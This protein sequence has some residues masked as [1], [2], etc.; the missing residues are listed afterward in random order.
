[1]ETE[2]KQYDFC[3]KCGALMEGGYCQSCGY[4]THENRVDTVLGKQKTPGGKGRGKGRI[5]CLA[6]LL[7]V[8]AA[9]LGV[10]GIRTLLGTVG[11]YVQ[12]AEKAG[13]PGKQEPYRGE[14][15]EEELETDELWD[16][17]LIRSQR[18]PAFELLYG[19][20]SVA[21]GRPALPAVTS[22]TYE[23]KPEDDFYRCLTDAIEYDLSYSV[24]WESMPVPDAEGGEVECTV[25]QV[26]MED[27]EKEERINAGILE[28]LSGRDER[29]LRGMEV[30][31]TYMSEE[32]LS[33]AGKEL[34]YYSGQDFHPFSLSAVS[35]DMSTG[36]TLAPEDMIEMTPGWASRFWGLCAY[37]HPDDQVV[38][39]FSY[40][41]PEE[42]EE[43]GSVLLANL[44]AL[45]EKIMDPETG[46]LFYT[47]VGLEAGFNH[48]DGFITVTFDREQ[49]LPFYRYWLEEPDYEPMA[50]DPYYRQLV[51]AI[52]DDLSYQV[53]FES[54][55]LEDETGRYHYTYPQLS[56]AGIPNLEEINARI[57]EVC[58]VHA[59][60]AAAGASGGMEILSYV[61][62]MDE[63]VISI[64]AEHLPY[65]LNSEGLWQSS[66][67]IDSITFDL[68]NGREI[69][70]NEIVEMDLELAKQFQRLAGE[71]E[72][73]NGDVSLLQVM[74]PEDLLK[75]D[76][77]DENHNFVFYTPAGIE[78]GYNEIQ[79]SYSVTIKEE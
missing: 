51:N 27:K 68:V 41:E 77:V 13:K 62:Y 12:M 49:S 74:N 37:E 56:G 76:L 55:S 75:N 53:E 44:N 1:M 31:V 19:N 54:F 33:I 78:V 22:L 67:S 30:Y 4:R 71:Q 65:T 36:G 52:Q 58:C 28:L 21:G 34:A 14:D 59:E 32:I 46:I 3:P 17:S 24:Q 40:A 50:S 8:A 16:G 60:E 39:T 9:A 23:P 64:V 43:A 2:K 29:E 5:V 10:H 7:S 66:S 61:T 20:Y 73:K 57:Q 47:P 70:K 25:P 38:D 69:P 72:K 45:S 26:E 42:V 79:Q 6:V 63:E 35:F 48:P 11:R 15:R 18:Y